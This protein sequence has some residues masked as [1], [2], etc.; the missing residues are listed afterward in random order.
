M[1]DQGYLASTLLYACTAH[2]PDLLDR[3]FTALEQVFRLIADCD[4]G[5]Q[6]ALAL[7]RGPVCHGGFKRLN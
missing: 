4:A 7:L 1:L 3:Y 2:T 6:D 5:R